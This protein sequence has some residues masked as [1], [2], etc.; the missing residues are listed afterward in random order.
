[1]HSRFFLNHNT[2]NKAPHVA[3][4]GKLSDLENVGIFLLSEVKT[5]HESP[6]PNCW[7]LEESLESTKK[8]WDAFFFLVVKK[9]FILETGGKPK[10]ILLLEIG[11]KLREKECWDFFFFFCSE[12]K[13]V[14]E[15]GGKLSE[16]MLGWILQ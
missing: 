6:P 7:K 2:N 1:L 10:E 3:I 15:I 9:R 8:C 14:L 13:F 12:E 5:F 11:G 16:R 4:G